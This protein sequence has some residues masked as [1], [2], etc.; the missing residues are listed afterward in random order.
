M[1]RIRTVLVSASVAALGVAGL[2]A[3]PAPAQAAWKKLGCT[4]AEVRGA[5]ICLFRDTANSNRAQGRYINHTGIDL[6]TKG[7][8]WRENST[9]TVGC[10]TAIT[11]AGTTSR[12]TRTLPSGKFYLGAYTW[13]GDSFIGFTA[14][15][16]Y[17]FGN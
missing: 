5:R 13:R 12:C 14:T 15:N 9:Q 1:P 4:P 3:A 8:F 16:A 10:A 11:E 6:K 7:V 2:L 17:R